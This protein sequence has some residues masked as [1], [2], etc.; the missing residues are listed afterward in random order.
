LS[1]ASNS[2]KL[3][4]SSSLLSLQQLLD[5]DSIPQAR[6]EAAAALAAASA[7]GADAEASE[8]PAIR[9]K[10]LQLRSFYS[11][12]FQPGVGRLRFV[13]SCTGGAVPVQHTHPA[14]LG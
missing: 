7:E 3:K 8:V 10:L 13:I 4:C 12:V 9:E 6:T 2:S 1:G 11:Q 14:V 5:L